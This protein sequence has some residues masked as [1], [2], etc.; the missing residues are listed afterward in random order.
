MIDLDEHYGGVE[1]EVDDAVQGLKAQ[2]E[3]RLQSL[4]ETVLKLK[5][6][7]GTSV[8]CIYMCMVYIYSVVR[9]NVYECMRMNRCQGNK[10]SLVCTLC[11]H[12]LTLAV[13]IM[14]IIART[15]LVIYIFTLTL[16]N[17]HMI[18]TGLM[19][20][21][22]AGLRL[23]ADECRAQMAALGVNER[24]YHVQ[25]CWYVYICM[26]TILSLYLCVYRCIYKHIVL[27]MCIYFVFYTDTYNYTTPII[28]THTLIH[29]PHIYTRVYIRYIFYSTLVSHVLIYSLDYYTYTCTQCTY[30]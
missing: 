6:E 26:S 10:F 30:I 11:T 29:K 19:R 21:K 15:S 20:K 5:G 12:I 18:Y 23:E 22:V 16:T 4:A 17:I 27:Y 25:V 9:V 2:S 3:A 8:V 14:V 24:A 7:T 1:E 13:Y 28:H